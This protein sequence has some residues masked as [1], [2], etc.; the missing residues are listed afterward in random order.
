[1]LWQPDGLAFV[2]SVRF[3]NLF[4]MSIQRSS[5]WEHSKRLL[6][7]IL[8]QSF[9]S[10]PSHDTLHLTCQ[11]T[12]WCLLNG[13]QL[14]ITFLWRNRSRIKVIYKQRFELRTFSVC[15]KEPGKIKDV[16]RGKALLFDQ[17]IKGLNFLWDLSNIIPDPKFKTSRSQINKAIHWIYKRHTGIQS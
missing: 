5:Q 3:L 9:V 2:T 11:S 14:Q 8:C 17:V 15:Y 10:A 1:M 7:C 4:L 16:C 12:W 13:Q 6:F